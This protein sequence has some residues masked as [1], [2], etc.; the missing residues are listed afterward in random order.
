M[1]SESNIWGIFGQETPNVIDPI[2]STAVL[3]DNIMLT[4]IIVD[5]RQENCVHTD[6][7]SAFQACCYFSIKNF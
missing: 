5:A 2:C 3:Y 7:H 1:L 6:L 4:I